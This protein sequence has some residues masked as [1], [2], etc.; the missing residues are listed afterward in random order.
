MF[1]LQEIFGKQ[2]KVTLDVSFKAE[3]IVEEKRG[4]NKNWYW[5]IVCKRGLIYPQSLDKNTVCIQTTTRIGK[6]LI[7]LFGTKAVFKRSGDS[8]FEFII[9]L[10]L[11]KTTFR[12]LKP[13][14]RRQ[15]TD[16]Q[17]AALITR[18]NSFR[19]AKCP[20]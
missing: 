8:E 19:K 4:S 13:K 11:V 16:S 18:L 10:D 14:K 20:Q 6:K 17:K 12:Y 2:V 7:R 15:L 9:P 1:S 5:E 3:K